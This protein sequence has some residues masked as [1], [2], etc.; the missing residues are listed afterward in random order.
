MYLFY[1]SV[2]NCVLICCL[3]FTQNFKEFCPNEQYV[4]GTLC[5][6]ICAWD[7]AYSKTQVNMSSCVF[8]LTKCSR[9]TNNYFWL[10]PSPPISFRVTD[11]SHFAAQSVHSLPNTTQD[12]RTT[13]A[14]YTGISLT[15][16][17]CST[18]LTAHSLQTRKLW[19]RISKY[20]I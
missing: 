17:F 9:I 14:M 7:P 10:L 12:T 18:A 16:V 5:L 13:S 15:A 19:R 11:L 3:F 20:S 2:I 8:C 4:Q 1:K 6:D